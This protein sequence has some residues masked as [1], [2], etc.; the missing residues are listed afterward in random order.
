MMV[1]V[2]PFKRRAD[3]AAKQRVLI[4]LGDCVEAGMKILM[5]LDGVDDSNGRREQAVDGALQIG[6]R[7]GVLDREC[8]HLRARMH[9]GVGASRSRDRN[10]ISFHG[11]DD[12]FERS[13]NGRKSWLDLPA[14]KLRAIVSDCDANAACQIR[15]SKFR[16][17]DSPR[18]RPG[19]CDGFAARTT[20][21]TLRFEHRH[22]Q[23]FERRARNAQ[24]RGAPAAINDRT[25]RNRF[26]ARGPHK[27][28]HLSGAASGGD[29]VLDHNGSL[30][31]RE[32]KAA[33]QRHL[34]CDRVSPLGENKTDA[35]RTRHLMP[36]NQTA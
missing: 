19:L 27:L 30:A 26:G 20:R 29:D 10:G 14:M 3:G 1:H 34:T 8:R 4:N 5:R 9:A 15:A 11:A 25:G 33:P 6:R 18:S 36:D 21:A 7:D 24:V 31:G 23:R 35:Q 32:R 16:P 17:A 28:D 13:L 2:T 12:L 22:G